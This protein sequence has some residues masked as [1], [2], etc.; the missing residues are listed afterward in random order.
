MHARRACCGFTWTIARP[1]RVIRDVIGFGRIQMLSLDSVLCP[2]CGAPVDYDAG[3]R[4]TTC[5]SCRN[6]LLVSSTDASHHVRSEIDPAFNEGAFGALRLVL[7]PRGTVVCPQCALIYPANAECCPALIKFAINWYCE[8]D[9]RHS[10]DSRS[11]ILE[12]IR[13]HPRSAKLF[14]A[15]QVLESE[16]NGECDIPVHTLREIADAVGGWLTDSLNQY[17]Q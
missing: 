13:N 6:E 9:D 17:A 1:A 11:N 8:A 2:C 10:V 12:F 7:H 16:I 3:C 4:A 14:M 15:V 5:D